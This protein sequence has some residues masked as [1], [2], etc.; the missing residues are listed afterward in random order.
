MAS[1]SHP[2]LSKS[3]MNAL[4]CRP[5][6]NSREQAACDFLSISFLYFCAKMA[7]WI[8][9]C[10]PLKLIRNIK[11]LGFLAKGVGGKRYWLEKGINVFSSNYWTL[12]FSKIP[13]SRLKNSKKNF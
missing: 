9:V 3:R 13:P 5:L 4:S 6:K 1:L 7:A 8:L 12:G 2:Q 11:Y 10:F